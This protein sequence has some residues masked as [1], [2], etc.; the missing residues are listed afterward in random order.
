M[1]LVVVQFINAK[2]SPP[3][4]PSQMLIDE[5][6]ENDIS[7]L[8]VLDY[9]SPKRNEPSSK[10]IIVNAI[11]QRPKN[12]FLLKRLKK[13][14]TMLFSL[15]CVVKMVDYDP[16]KYPQ[17]AHLHKKKEKAEIE[18]T[19]VKWNSD[20]NFGFIKY[21]DGDDSVFVHF[22]NLEFL[23]K[24]KINTDHYNLWLRD[25]APVRFFVD[26]NKVTG[27]SQATRVN[28]RDESDTIFDHF[29]IQP[30]NG[31]NSEQVSVLM[32]FNKATF[33]RKFCPNL[34]EAVFLASK[35]NQ[36]ENASAHV[37]CRIRENDNGLFS[38]RE[39]ASKL[40]VSC[41]NDILPID[42]VSVDTPGCPLMDVIEF[43]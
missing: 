27:T 31:G 18:G 22:S 25:T 28:F 15:D 37:E 14:G 11:M 36:E 29:V 23:E 40:F 32:L 13:I 6:D 8:Q 35:I 41:K 1:D 34:L 26:T 42:S 43:V 9:S 21:G 38:T 5:L 16:T 33:H 10:F 2:V 17:F 12:T 4:S 39:Q 30:R 20:R 7:F 24:A 3:G 19:L